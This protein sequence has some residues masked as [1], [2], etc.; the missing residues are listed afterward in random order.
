MVIPEKKKKNTERSCCPIGCT[1]YD[2]IDKIDK[3][4]SGDFI[5]IVLVFDF[6]IDLHIKGISIWAAKSLDL[7]I[8]C[9]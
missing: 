8:M 5:Q 9:L 4:D 1:K 6:F 2:K 7:A 3:I